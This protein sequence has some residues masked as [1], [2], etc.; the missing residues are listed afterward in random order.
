M[1]E[2]DPILLIP[3]FVPLVVGF[4]L[5][6]IPSK[7]LTTRLLG[8]V[9]TLAVAMFTLLVAF[10][11]LLKGQASYAWASVP[12]VGDLNLAL[13]LR[14][15][16]L[17]T[18]ILIFVAVF[19]LLIG[20]YS[21]SAATLGIKRVGEFYG[22]ILL[23]LGGSAGILLAD[24]ILCLLIFWEI[25]TAALYILITT[26]G[27]HS[28]A[29]ATKSFAMLGASDAALLVGLLMAAKL[30]GTSVISEMQISTQGTLPVISFLLILLAALTKAGSMPLHT[31][32]PTSGE[33]A[34]SVVMA[35][36]PAALDK[37]L[38][39]Y[40]LVLMVRQIFVMVSGP[41]TMV[42]TVVGAATIIAAVMVAMVQ[43]NVKRLLSYHAISQVG[44]M[45]LGIATGT[46]IGIAGGLFHMLNNAIYKSC[47][48]LCGGAVEQQTSTSELEE[49]GGLGRKMP[50]TF[51]ACL[52][53]ALSISG[54]P[55]FNGFVSKWMV[56]QGVIEMGA[57]QGGWAAQCWPIW[58]VC[59]MFGSALTL[60]SFVKI[61][62]SVFL[63]RLPGKLQQTRE[64]S[65][66]QA[67][68]MGVLAGL[69]VLFGVFYKIPLKWFIYPALDIQE[70]TQILGAEWS[71][72]WVTLL[73]LLGVGVGAGILILGGFL[74]KK[75]R[76]VPTWTCGERQANEQMIIPGTHFYKTVSSMN[77][78]KQIYRSQEKG[79]FDPYDHS[80]KAG[81]AMTG[82]LRWL[83]NG[84]LSA[85]LTWVV[86]GLLL[87]VIILC[88]IK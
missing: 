74:A 14:A 58:L 84:V 8:C 20:L 49:L 87:I 5:L 18:F 68:P 83:H 44:Y 48:F 2:S 80:G 69:C 15:D 47:L 70:S 17:R 71:A 26:G 9:C 65:P 46:T 54:I 42:L 12:L 73:L 55:P 29:A 67:V 37:L 51:V 59:A 82:L 1:A 63:S 85:Y 23:A 10:S 41:L 25:V 81:L 57:K 36:L 28:N 62:H 56:Y 35:L 45:V 78:L 38:G 32:L 72:G 7:T 76:I 11:I 22:S 16:P 50:V 75:I 19:G 33:S 88:Q 40:L 31:W 4:I 27:R 52:I 79:H 3:V 86:L 66:I 39:I 64:V 13:L 6:F 30:A 61:L 34:P 24:H 43:H 21:F 77:G 53:A 60:A